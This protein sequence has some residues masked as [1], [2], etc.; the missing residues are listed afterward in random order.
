MFVGA[1]TKLN[2]GD[3]D[4]CVADLKVM[5]EKYPQSGL[6][7]MAGM[8]V[9][10]VGEG[11]RL[12]GGTFDIGNVWERRTVTLNNNDTTAVRQ[13][14]AERNANFVF[15]IAY[16]PD[17]VDANRLLFELA[18]YNFTSYLVRNFDINIEDD[19]ALQRMT[20]SGFRNFDEA[21]QYARSL[22]A[23]KSVTQGTLHRGQ[24]G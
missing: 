16:Q 11:R 5:L 23:Q 10:G 9:R 2:E 8:I 3:A 4:S 21:L 22:Y 20:V 14:S 7:E 6:A 1:L 24:R 17:S 18:R 12:R 15:M 13:L 19:G